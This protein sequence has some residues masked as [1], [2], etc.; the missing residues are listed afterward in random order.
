M[1][2]G[3]PSGVDLAP[4]GLPFIGEMIDYA[5]SLNFGELPNYELLHSQVQETRERAG[6]LDSFVVDWHIPSD[7]LR[8][9]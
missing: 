4:D 8:G 7:A 6:L 9:P 2:Q 1:E 5:R 3:R